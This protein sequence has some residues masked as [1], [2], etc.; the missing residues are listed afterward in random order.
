MKVGEDVDPSLINKNVSFLGGGWSR[1][2]VKEAAYL[3]VY[4]DAF[5]L[6]N[7]ANAYVNPLTACA[8]L[9][10][11]QKHGAKSILILAASSSLAKQLIRLC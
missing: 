9:D 10:F 7:G 8:M 2:T 5:D 11:A 1:Y 6:K 4:E 3:L